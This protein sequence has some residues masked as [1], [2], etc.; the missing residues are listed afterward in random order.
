M[1]LRPP[2][3]DREMLSGS[4]DDGFVLALQFDHGDLE[5]DCAGVSTREGGRRG[6]GRG[7]RAKREAERCYQVVPSTKMANSVEMIV[8]H[9]LNQLKANLN[10]FSFNED[11]VPRTSLHSKTLTLLR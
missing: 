7:P 3:L 2:N 11:D 6:G 1:G 5:P 9:Q 8:E 10:S 4:V